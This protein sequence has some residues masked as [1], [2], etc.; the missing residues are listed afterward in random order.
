MTCSIDHSL[1]DVQQK[2]ESQKSYLPIELYEASV[3]YL[4]T[5]SHQ[6][7]LNEMFHLLKKYDLVSEE[8]KRIREASLATLLHS[9]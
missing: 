3:R 8:E 1:Q 9:A 4:E 6:T 7:A 5:A 2:L